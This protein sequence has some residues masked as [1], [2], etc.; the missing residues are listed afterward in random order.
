MKI[1]VDTS[2]LIDYLR[3]GT[4]WQDFLIEVPRNAE[5]FLP[6]IVVFELFSDKS[7]KDPKIVSKIAGLL[8]KFEKIELTQEIAERAGQL[9]RDIGKQI[10]GSS[11][12]IR[13]FALARYI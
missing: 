6:T 12:D 13:G 5:L 4:K 7:T 1:I 11:F 10:R 8:L 2:I 3:A 9:Y